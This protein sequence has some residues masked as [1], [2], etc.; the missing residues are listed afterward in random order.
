MTDTPQPTQPRF[1]VW[2]AFWQGITHIFVWRG[3]ATRLEFWTFW[4]VTY[5]IGYG[6]GILNYYYPYQFVTA[7]CRVIVY[8]FGFAT[9]SYA[10]RR[11]HDTN[12]ST[13]QFWYMVVLII[14]FGYGTIY[15]ADDWS[16]G[17]SVLI[18]ASDKLS[19]VTVTFSEKMWAYAYLS[20]PFVLCGFMVWYFI[21]L[22]WILLIPSREPNR[23]N[24]M[25]EKLDWAALWVMS[26]LMFFYPLR[27]MIMQVGNTGH[28]SILDLVAP[29]VYEEIY[30][31][32]GKRN[33]VTTEDLLNAL[34]RLDK[35]D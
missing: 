5:V 4:F 22:V 29:P 9:V 24:Q 7:I 20:A 32:D 33:S 28:L 12:R 1:S 13:F 3:R 23:Y 21:R 27:I 30:N 11:F 14:L 15:A 16:D 2:T 25:P 10:I 31:L 8:L 34:Y 6:L 18:T 19:Q 35:A 26:F 17:I